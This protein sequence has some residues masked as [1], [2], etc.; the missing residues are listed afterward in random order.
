[1]EVTGGEEDMEVT[2][3]EEGREGTKVEEDRKVEEVRKVEE[4]RKV[5]KG[6]EDWEGTKGEEAMEVTKGMEDVE[7]EHKGETRIEERRGGRKEVKQRLAELKLKLNQARNLNTKEVADEKL[8]AGRDPREAAKRKRAEERRTE[9]NIQREL[10]KQGAVFTNRSILEETAEDAERREMKRLK[11]RVAPEGEVVF[12]QE[13]LGIA[14]E[15]RIDTLPQYDDAHTIVKRVDDI[16]YGTAP[17]IPKQNIE[18]MVSPI[19]LFKTDFPTQA[20]RHLRTEEEKNAKLRWNSQSRT[21]GEPCT[22]TLSIPFSP[23]PHGT[24]KCR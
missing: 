11:K 13:F 2:R 15:K 18:N 24:Q 6:D 21:S 16:E 23:Y 1:M 10:K 3:G 12:G 5:E 7:E 4:D 9:K 22:D 14:F 20:N 17:Q 19:P 8:R